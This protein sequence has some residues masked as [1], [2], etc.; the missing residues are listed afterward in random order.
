M[1]DFFEHTVNYTDFCFLI[2]DKLNEK[3]DL[4]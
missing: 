2:L 1:G 4:H 3:P